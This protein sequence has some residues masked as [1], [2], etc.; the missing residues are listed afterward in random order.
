MCDYGEKHRLIVAVQTNLFADA[1]TSI[2]ARL[3]KIVK[4]REASFSQS[5]V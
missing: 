3:P 5:Q 4:I 2:P 1:E